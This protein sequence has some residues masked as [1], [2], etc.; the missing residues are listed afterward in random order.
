MID[1]N[2]RIVVMANL[3]SNVVFAYDGDMLMI[4]RERFRE[5]MLR[6]NGRTVGEVFEEM[7]CKGRLRREN[8]PKLSYQLIDIPEVVER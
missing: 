7:L 1:A 5:A 6:D 2:P 4:N 8:C 3:P